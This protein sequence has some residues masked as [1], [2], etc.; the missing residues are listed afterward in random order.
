MTVRVEPATPGHLERLLAGDDD[1]CRAYG[2]RVADGY[3]EFPG[4]VEN[5][6]KRVR[7]GMDVTWWMYLIVHED[8]ATLIG[9][10]GF[11][12]PP[13]DGSVEIGYAIA[14]AYRQLGHATRAAQAFVRIARDA[15]VSTVVAHTLPDHNASTKVLG[16]CGFQF[17]GEVVDPDDGLIWRWELA[18]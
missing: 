17:V 18:L 3:V 2:L 8:D 12:G 16:R 15:G 13:D 5:T 7:T 9:I 6:L 4:V 1:F 10:G 11:K 14:P